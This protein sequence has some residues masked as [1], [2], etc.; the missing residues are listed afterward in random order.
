VTE[1]ED[2]RRDIGYPPK[3]GYTPVMS[4]RAVL[5]RPS[6]CRVTLRHVTQCHNVTNRLKPTHRGLSCVTLGE[7][8]NISHAGC[9]SPI[10]EAVTLPNVTH[11]TNREALARIAGFSKRPVVTLASPCASRTGFRFGC[12]KSAYKFRTH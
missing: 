12:P 1:A 6:N 5:V 10:D 7:C 8:G 9:R 2:L 11:V 3:G 4:P